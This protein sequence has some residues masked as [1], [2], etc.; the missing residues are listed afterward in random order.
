MKDKITFTGPFCEILP[1][2]ICFKRSLGFDY[3]GNTLQRL[4]Q[5]DDFFKNMGVT[6]IRI[7]REQAENYLRKRPG[8]K[9]SSH[10]RRFSV[11]HQ[12]CQYLHEKHY[13]GIHLCSDFP[14]ANKESYLPYIYS[15]E[16][17]SKLFKA[18]DD[19]PPRAR[20]PKYHLIYPILIRLLYSCGL[21][22]SE[23]L[24]LK[25]SDINT[26][27]HTFVIRDGKNHVSRMLPIS[28]SMFHTLSKYQK[29]LCLDQEDLLFSNNQNHKY[30]P[31]S[32]NFLFL[33]I[34]AKAGIQRNADGYG[35]RLHDLRHTFCVHTLEKMIDQGTDI[36]TALPILS[37]YLGHAS[38][39]STE[40][41]VRLT[42]H[43]FGRICVGELNRIIPETGGSHG[44]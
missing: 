33:K 31:S 7:T 43:H 41:Y 17:I 24:D 6:E 23:A 14:R 5:M 11:L 44:A 18:C 8:E 42:K 32:I 35:P 4:R 38:I 30:H 29:A 2:Y 28:D 39:Y 12:F 19:L 22:I 34:L 40:H 27:E 36:Y 21:R 1:E 13:D 9:D 15:K 20:Y 25:M 10:Y 37:Q 16:E 26:Q 3:Q